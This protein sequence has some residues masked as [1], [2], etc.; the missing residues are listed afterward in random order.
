MLQNPAP[1]IEKLCEIN[2]KST[3]EIISKIGALILL[4]PPNL[5]QELTS[6]LTNRIL[7]FE[8][9]E[10]VFEFITN[11]VEGP[12]FEM[13]VLPK[14]LEQCVTR[15]LDP[16]SL[17][18]LTRILVEKAPPRL[19]GNEEIR[20]YPIDFPVSKQISMEY[21]T[22]QRLFDLLEIG[23]KELCNALIALGHIKHV[24]KGKVGETILRLVSE[25]S[26]DKD[27][28]IVLSLAV[29]ALIRCGQ[30]GKVQMVMEKHLDGLLGLVEKEEL[31]V[32]VLRVLDIGL[33]CATEGITMELLVKLNGYL[34]DLVAS[35]FSEV[36]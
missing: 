2:L 12:S 13:L 21:D 35:P 20:L 22:S 18:V 27:G 8:N 4:H 17:E 14:F 30:I 9:Q 25:I 7:N 15:K 32:G 5:T 16:K 11:V 19:N 3:D 26:L 28:L 33:S 6:K 36:S 10:I 1:I 24:D 23:N 29:D 31:V 34:L